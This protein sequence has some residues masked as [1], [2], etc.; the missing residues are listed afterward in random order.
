MAMY[1]Q[2]HSPAYAYPPQPPPVHSSQ[3]PYGAPSS[4]YL[5]DPISF[6][7][8][9]AARL[10]ELTVNSRP[11]IQNLSM[12]AQEYS[13]WA[14]VVVDCLDA[15]IRRVPPWMKLPAFYLLDAISK[16]VHDPYAGHFASIV[17]TLFLETYGQVDQGTRSKMEEM[18]LTWRTGAPNGRELFGIGPQIAIERGIWG[19][20]TNAE[21][22]FGSGFV[23]KSQ[24]MSEL[25][26]ALGQKE[27]ALQANPYDSVTQSHVNVLQ[28]LRKLVEAG[29]SQEE[30]AQILSQLR[31]LV[32]VSNPSPPPAPPVPRYPPSA[33]YPTSNTYGQPPM[34]QAGPSS[35][36]L[37]AAPPQPAP[38]QYDQPHPV[39]DS[40][41]LLPNAGSSAPLGVPNISNLYEALLK[42][43]VVSKTTT[44]TG[45]PTTQVDEKKPVVDAGKEEA[46]AYRNAILS[47]GIKFNSAEI[48]RHRPNIVHFLYERLS[49]Q[50]KQCG[51]R[52]SETALGKEKMKDHL[53]MHFR[54]NRKASQNVG[55]GH[56]RSWF[57]SVEDWIH[58]VSA[59]RKGK[60][61]ADPSRPQNAKAA[62]AAETA[63]RDAELLSQYVVVPPGDE[64]KLIAC[65]IC[66]E[67]LKSE[68]QEEDEEWVWKNAVKIDDRIYHA[69]CHAEA[70]T[71]TSSLAAR[72]RQE[73]AGAGRSRS[74]TPES[75]S[76]RATP[77]RGV[78]KEASLSPNSK[79]IGLKRKGSFDHTLGSGDGESGSP[80]AKK[81]MLSA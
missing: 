4:L 78:K 38:P 23:S 42:A 34:M 41:P 12:I 48:S 18:L 54:Q 29:V 45:I 19:A 65:P 62:A 46:V 66:K 27:R 81:I 24:V 13:R 68:F 50:C 6:R 58:D 70:L 51:I 2:S 64:A 77:P 7:R 22:T 57:V 14:D 15:H 16:N 61:P 21:P 67:T 63:K 69:T 60:G 76:Q 20:G 39:A 59:D 37:T 11:I 49:V 28:Q 31:N 32:R 35:L 10:S 9:Y 33:P 47:Q 30:L 75:A 3:Y 74:G 5:L 72:L 56:S 53:D 52:F 79:A 73:I 36:P 80:P 26:F 55:R 8:D 1:S 40:A 25:E 43:G 71:S 44:P 17:A